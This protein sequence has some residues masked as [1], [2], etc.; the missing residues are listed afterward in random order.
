MA[1]EAREL[2]YAYG[3]T[4]PSVLEH[5]SLS[6]LAGQRVALTGFKGAGRSTLLRLLGGL[7]D[8]YEGTLLVDRV[9]MHDV[10]RDAMRERVGQVLSLTDLF[11]GS[12]ADNVSVGRSHIG[13][14]EIW[15]AIR[16]VGLEDEILSMRHGLETRITNGGRSLPSHI[17]TKLLFAQGI[18]GSPRLV[19]F[20]DLF[21][22]LLAED[23]RR[24]LAILSDPTREWTV[25]AVSH[26]PVLLEAFDR[27][28]VIRDGTI[29][30]D[31][32]F[33]EVREDP[34]CAG[35]LDTHVR[36]GEMARAVRETGAIGGAA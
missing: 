3:K 19:L 31:G 21:M 32:G 34:Y 6:I 8:D 35:L 33:A 23:R 22:N 2:S 15:D 16:L 20:D 13:E 4:G 7:L 14:T 9:S 36:T 30:A 24:L 1:M 28:I 26:D 17:A 11:E 29:A 18:A 5:V 10:D 25:I 12:I 27:V